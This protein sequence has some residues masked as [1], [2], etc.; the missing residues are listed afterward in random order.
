MA[1]EKAMYWMAVCVLALAVAN[2]WVSEHSGW[3][4]R[5]AAGS[6][7]MA[8]HASELA[9]GFAD[10]GSPDRENNDDVN[11]LVRAQVR[12]ARVQS[13]LARH[14]AD[15]ARVQANAIHVHMMDRGIHSVLACPSQNFVIHL[16]QPPQFG[17]D[18]F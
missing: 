18:R 14:R 12:M 1:S 6:I 4:V 17:D 5:L 8:E 15:M 13:T 16:P 3:A 9:A 2:G 10:V 11:R 7:A